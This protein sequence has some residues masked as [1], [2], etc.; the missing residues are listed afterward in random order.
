MQIC[1]SAS[2]EA[3]CR[4]KL[5]MRLESTGKNTHALSSDTD[6]RI[7]LN[8]RRDASLHYR[9]PDSWHAARVHLQPSGTDTGSPPTRFCETPRATLNHPCRQSARAGR[10]RSGDPN[11][12]RL[13]RKQHPHLCSQQVAG[14]STTQ[15]NSLLMFISAKY[16]NGQLWASTGSMPA[17][18][19]CPMGPRM[20]QAGKKIE[21]LNCLCRQPAFCNSIP[22]KPTI[23]LI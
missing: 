11:S 21:C 14:P 22:D 12:R 13:P 7:L 10:P 4:P 16:Y 19:C 8:A 17:A 23:C 6:P 5:G 9:Q 2:R 20:G 3:G 15:P 18:A 1:I